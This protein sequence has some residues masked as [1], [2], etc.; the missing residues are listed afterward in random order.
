MD[1][2]PDDVPAGSPRAPWNQPDAPE[3][4]AFHCTH[5]DLDITPGN[6]EEGD[7]CPYHDD[8]EQPCEGTLVAYYSPD[9]PDWDSMPGGADDY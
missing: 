1:N 3:P 6:S 5:C 8:A 9:E 4:D 7:S 2:Y